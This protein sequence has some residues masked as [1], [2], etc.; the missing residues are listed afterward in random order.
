M[1]WFA[2]DQKIIVKEKKEFQFRD[3]KYILDKCNWQWNYKRQ[4][5][6]KN[7]RELN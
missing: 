3:V 1:N 5:N 7:K 6:Y 2:K 4:W